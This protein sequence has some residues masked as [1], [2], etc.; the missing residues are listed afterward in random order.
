[1]LKFIKINEIIKKKLMRGPRK[2]FYYTFDR[3]I[4]ININHLNLI[5][6]KLIC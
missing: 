5:T 2:Y 3:L 6:Q 4:D 1:M